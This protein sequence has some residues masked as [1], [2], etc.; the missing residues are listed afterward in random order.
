MGENMN[1]IN[2]I[3][4]SAVSAVICLVYKTDLQALTTG[5]SMT[6]T[7]T[8]SL[9]TNTFNAT[10]CSNATVCRYE[11]YTLENHSTRSC[12][13]RWAKRIWDKCSGCVIGDVQTVQVCNQG[14]YVSYCGT[15]PYTGNGH[16]G[17]TP[18]CNN[19]PTVGLNSVA[20]NTNG[21]SYMT[22]FGKPFSEMYVYVCS[23]YHP[24]TGS[25]STSTGLAMY[26]VFIDCTG[27]NSAHMNAIED[28]FVKSAV[29]ITDAVGSYRFLDSCNYT[30]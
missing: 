27:Y 12:A 30:E 15:D 17:F 20:G 22:S 1:K 9:G 25:G 18:V 6:I 29:S 14:Q 19:C 24:V 5:C 11:E 21:V 2:K 3:L 28:C 13:T 23:Q 7:S 16:C 8:V 26:E 10:V 4:W